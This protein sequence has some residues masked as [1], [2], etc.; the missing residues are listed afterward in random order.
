MAHP[1]P[2]S[3]TLAGARPGPYDAWTLGMGYIAA[4]RILDD[5]E[6]FTRP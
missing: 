2:R 5:L 3:D 1:K 4:V 6:R